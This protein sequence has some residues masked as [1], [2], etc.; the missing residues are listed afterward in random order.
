MRPRASAGLHE[1]GVIVIKLLLPLLLAQ[2]SIAGVNVYHQYDAKKVVEVSGGISS[3]ASHPGI[4]DSGDIIFKATSGGVEEIRISPKVGSDYA[5]S[6]VVANPPDGESFDFVGQLFLE[7]PRFYNVDPNALGVPELK[8]GTRLGE[9]KP[10]ISGRTGG[11]WAGFTSGKTGAVPVATRGCGLAEGAAQPLLTKSVFRVRALPAKRSNRRTSVPAFGTGS[12]WCGEQGTRY[13]ILEIQLPI[14][15][16]IH[17]DIVLSAFVEKET[18][19]GSS[20]ARMVLVNHVGEFEENPAPGIT[21]RPKFEVVAETG[22]TT[23]RFSAPFGFTFG[24]PQINDSGEIGFVG[25]TVGV[26]EPENFSSMRKALLF[27][28][29]V[30]GQFQ[31]TPIFYE[32]SGHAPPS[33]TYVGV[34]GGRPTINNT[35][36]VGV[37]VNLGAN[38]GAQLAISDA[39]ALAISGSP[40]TQAKDCATCYFIAGDH[41]S[42]VNTLNSDI[43]LASKVVELGQITSFENFS[44]VYGAYFTAGYVSATEPQ[45]FKE[46]LFSSDA[47]REFKGKVVGVGEELEAGNVITGIRFSRGSVSP[48]G[49]LVFQVDTASGSFIYAFE[50]CESKGLCIDIGQGTYNPDPGSN[51]FGFVKLIANRPTVIRF[52]AIDP[53]TGAP[54]TLPGLGEPEKVVS[55]NLSISNGL[56]ESFSTALQPGGYGY[57]VLPGHAVVKGLLRVIEASDVSGAIARTFASVVESKN[58]NIGY[59]RFGIVSEEQGDFAITASKMLLKDF[60]PVSEVSGGFSTNNLLNIVDGMVADDYKLAWLLAQKTNRTQAIAIVDNG[61]FGRKGENPKLVGLTLR[62]KFPSPLEE[63]VFSST[64]GIVW[65]TTSTGPH[66]F[67]HAIGGRRAHVALGTTSDAYGVI[68]GG[69]FGQRWGAKDLML[70][71]LGKFEPTWISAEDYNLM[72]SKL[73]KTSESFSALPRPRL[74]D[75]DLIGALRFSGGQVSPDTVV[76]VGGATESISP[77]KVGLTGPKLAILDGA[78][79]EIWAISSPIGFER[80]IVEEVTESTGAVSYVRSTENTADGYFNFRVPFLVGAATIVLGEGFRTDFREDLNSLV[81]RSISNLIPDRAILGNVDTFRK[82]VDSINSRLRM[83]GLSGQYSAANGL[84]VAEL[85]P[86]FSTSV[87]PLVQVPDLS[88][89]EYSRENAIADARLISQQLLLIAGKVGQP[90]A[91]LSLQ[92]DKIFY[93]AGERARLVA[94]PIVELLN[95]ELEYAVTAEV[96]GTAQRIERVGDKFV[97]ETSRLT[98]GTHIWAVRVFLQNRREALALESALNS[99]IETLKQIERELDRETDAEKIADLLR[100]KASVEARAATIEEALDGLRK[101]IGA[102]QSLPLEFR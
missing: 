95:P 62:P 42:R 18:L 17:G 81:V 35:G 50:S 14:S 43:G 37:Y 73:E 32:H 56:S 24:S 79:N 21:Q 16:N 23:D 93:N 59:Q 69:Q 102:V 5:S 27:A 20:T 89:L 7:E 57:I 70:E 80:E 78:G 97:G 26:L 8:E 86:L 66:E 33:E 38:G 101:P 46:G 55:L 96:N 60:F 39:R 64:V 68:E 84:L 67:V 99:V 100:Q 40:D 75:G 53:S 88:P 6:I 49:K 13:T 48:K 82:K 83:L 92:S 65:D 44:I 63:V 34:L 54:Y 72:V 25:T 12:T 15:M 22:I 51:G 74:F 10:L 76:P 1:L 52:R 19:S 91:L 47:S 31:I 94:T 4:N 58:L 30:S 71:R 45:V 9:S 11:F 85:L 2:N 3:I 36:Q 90:K 98:A 28:S 87:K 29:K 77:V 61:Y 41:R